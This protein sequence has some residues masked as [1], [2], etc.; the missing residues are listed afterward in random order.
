M[1][2]K[3]L[4]LQILVVLAAPLWAQEETI[5][6]GHL[7]D[8]SLTTWYEISYR[9]SELV[10]YFYEKDEQD[11]LSYIL[12]YWEEEAY[13]LE[14]IRRAWIL[15]QIAQ[16][17]FESDFV[18]TTM[19]DDFLSYLQTLEVQNED[20]LGWRLESDDTSKKG[21]K[22]ISGEFNAFT[23]DLSNS[24]LKFTDLS[25]DEYM[26]CL[27]YSHHFDEFWDILKS[28]EARYT[29]LAQN[30]QR[31][32][33]E[34]ASGDIHFGVFLGHYSPRKDF[35]LFGDKANI[36]GTV[37][38][39]WRRFYCDLSLLF[40]F[41]NSKNNY[42]VYYEKELFETKHYFRFYFGVEPAFQ[43][44]DW[45]HTKV[46]LLSGIGADVVEVVP[47]GNNPFYEEPITIAGVNL[48]LGIGFRHYLKSGSPW[49]VYY[50][51]RYEFSGYD[52]N[53]GTEL[54]NGE[55]VSLRLGFSWDENR[56]KHQFK[57][58]FD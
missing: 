47:E 27:F 15:G 58:Y 52:T 1:L 29:T 20:S 24:L 42:G 19:V 32:K 21:P 5:E 34:T 39:E 12:Q 22:F 11:S 6:L 45:E 10:P 4:L 54:S 48:N 38:A 43:L 2:K 14:P 44:W 18:S 3:L 30:V 8:D 50:Q 7:F 25:D 16:N 23:R 46:N 13:T 33:R 37:G 40:Q 53:G 31:Y 36:G 35:L 41:L 51:L 49:C 56:R 57:K 55:A 28:G 9:C 26:I 17:T